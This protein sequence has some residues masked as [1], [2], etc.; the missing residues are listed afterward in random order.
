M[1]VRWVSVPEG[2]V[3]W[4][5]EEATSSSST[6]TTCLPHPHLYHVFLLLSYSVFLHPV[7]CLTLFLIISSPFLSTFFIS[8]YL[9]FYSLSSINQFSSTLHFLS[10]FVISIFLPHTSYF[11]S[12][13]FSVFSSSFI[14]QPPTLYHLP[15]YFLPMSSLPMSSIFYPLAF[16]H[17]SIH[18]GPSPSTLRLI[19]SFPPS[20]SYSVTLT[21]ISL[22]PEYFSVPSNFLGKN[23]DPRQD[24]LIAI[25][26]RLF[27]VANIGSGGRRTFSL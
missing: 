8:L 14:L 15:L 1:L 11:L 4:E 16:H 2:E 10:S 27:S 13:L 12:A 5:W 25:Y 21:V 24:L 6:H 23:L 9:L 26:S 18:P 22:P 19:H 3:C 17:L 7:S 20:P